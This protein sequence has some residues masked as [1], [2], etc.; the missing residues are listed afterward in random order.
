MN[1]RKIRVLL[2]GPYIRSGSKKKMKNL[3]VGGYARN[4]ITYINYFKSEKIEVIPSFHTVR[5]QLKFDNFVWR[6]IVDTISFF[7]DIFSKNI[8]IVHIL[9]QYRT[10]I[11]RE[12]MVVFVSI[13]FNKKVVYEIKA[14]IFMNWYLSTNS[15][16]KWLTRYIIK[17]SNCILA[18]G[19][20]Y[21]S[22]IK[23]EFDKKAIYFPN[24]VP[25]SVIPKKHM[26][27]LSDDHLKVLFV[28][29]CYEGKGVFELVQGC[30]LAAKKGHKIVLTLVGSEQIEF[31]RW[32]NNYSTNDNLT[33]NRQG[34]KLFDEVLEIFKENDVFCFPS[35]HKSEGHSNSINEAMMNGLVIIS[36]KQGFLDSI[37]TDE[38][39]YSIK[40]IHPKTISDT[41]EDILNAPEIAKEKAKNAY[42]K[43]R[44]NYSSEKL[45]KKLI[46]IYEVL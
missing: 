43:L 39:G 13:L 29:Y 44:N 33:V 17:Q 35:I 11:P 31:T 41:L 40:D 8:E 14:G 4:M 19:E 23:Q 16:F 42:W 32:L 38:T 21:L 46:Q 2:Y 25:S 30:N 10:A 9:G 27:I 20:I 22:F 6:F 28:G 45:Y 37:I 24:Y 5:G 1:K 7:K 3:A 36:S 34:P 26:E 12:F 15:I 18:E